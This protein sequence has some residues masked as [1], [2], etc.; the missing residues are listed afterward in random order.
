[1]SIE[2]KPV[3]LPTQIL[4]NGGNDEAKICFRCGKPVALEKSVVLEQDGGIAE[5]HDFGVPPELSQGP[6]LFGDVCAKHMRKRARYALEGKGQSS[7]GPQQYLQNME[8]IL[9]K[10]AIETPAGHP[11]QA[12]YEF[13]LKAVRLRMAQLNVNDAGSQS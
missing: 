10:R 2:I 1:M 13:M 7:I 3:K 5:W 9:S 11:F 6:A 12:H 8:A 4:P